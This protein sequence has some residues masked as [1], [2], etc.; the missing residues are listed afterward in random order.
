MSSAVFG[1]PKFD[2]GSHYK[3]TEGPKAG[4]DTVIRILPPMFSMR[5]AG[6]WKKYWSTHWGYAGVNDTDPGKTSMRPFRCILDTDR[7][8]G[9][10]RQ[11]CP[12]CTRYA[13]VEAEKKQEEAKITARLK[14]EEGITDEKVIKET[15][16]AELESISQWLKAYR[17]EGKFYVN[18]MSED[19]TFGS[20]KLN[21]KFHMSRIKEFTNGKYEKGKLV[22]PS[23]LESDGINP[24]AV[25]QGVWFVISRTGNGFGTPDTTDIKYEKVEALVN[26]KKMMVPQIVLAPLTEEQCERAG[27]E[28]QDL[29][30]MGGRE[31]TFEQIKE[32][33]ECDGT[34]AEVDRIMG[35]ERKQ[36][37]SSKPTFTPPSEKRA[38]P[39]TGT[40]TATSRTAPA[41]TASAA[42]PAPASTAKPATTTAA[43]P[44]TGG[45]KAKIDLND[46]AV[47][48][49][50]AAIK[51]KKAAE[52]EARK[53]AEEEAAA[54]AAEEE[55]LLLAAAAEE[56][57]ASAPASEATVDQA[58]MSDEDFMASIGS[59]PGIG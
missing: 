12:A 23:L 47:Q 26:G 34:P 52:E 4:S 8:T 20:F 37:A 43:A 57:A 15:V 51:A 7:R 17:V 29:M 54:K 46:P 58:D 55:A 10:V 28:C 3:K 13:A 49:R 21:S 44:A 24:L 59:G 9:M 19:G 6:E 50:L 27:K 2:S 35:I 56:A 14:E 18:I 30:T 42:A 31:L 1:T 40:A 22:K 16:E 11:E 45:V 33:V 5:E 36:K 25:D 53:K 38:A 32:L 39:A 41:S 48:A